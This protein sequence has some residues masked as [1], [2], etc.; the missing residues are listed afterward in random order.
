MSLQRTTAIFPREYRS[1]G[2]EIKN[3]SNLN[4]TQVSSYNSTSSK[5][6]SGNV[7]PLQ[8]PSP[9]IKSAEINKRPSDLKM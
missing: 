5:I 9:A 6:S 4:A 8:L 3:T 2:T 1:S 7:T